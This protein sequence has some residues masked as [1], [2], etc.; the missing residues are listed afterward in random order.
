MR[1]SSHGSVMSSSLLPNYDS[2]IESIVWSIDT[3]KAK[4]VPIVRTVIT[5][6]VPAKYLC[7]LVL[8]LLDLFLIVSATT[9]ASSL[10]FSSCSIKLYKRFSWS[11]VLID[12]ASRILFYSRQYTIS[13]K[14]RTIT[15]WIA[16][17][18]GKKMNGRPTWYSGEVP[19]AYLTAGWWS[20]FFFM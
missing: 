15:I 18:I 8:A 11:S 13:L 3:K 9:A 1:E 20:Y 16:R 2:L 7:K 14:G 19:S 4:S 12:S 10:D 17:R 6:M 5:I